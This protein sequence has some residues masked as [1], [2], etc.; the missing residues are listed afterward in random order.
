[1]ASTEP[2]TPDLTGSADERLSQLAGHDS[3]TASPEWLRRQLISALEAWGSDETLLDI[4]KE[5]RAD[6]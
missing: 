5:S 3:L 6:F 1:M 2:Q 4:D